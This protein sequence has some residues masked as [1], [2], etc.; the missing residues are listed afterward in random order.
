[1]PRHKH[2]E[3]LMQKNLPVALLA[4]P[5]VNAFLDALND[6][7]QAMERDKQLTEHAFTV[8]ERE[9][10]DALRQIER[11]NREK[12]R[13]IEQI[14]TALRG[15]V[16]DASPDNASNDINHALDLL[17]QVIQRGKFH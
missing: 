14:E 1:M 6:A 8:S 5:G 11:E 16:S 4:D 7:F 2:L 10:Q 3:R 15:L 13:N 9:Y 17:R 12:R